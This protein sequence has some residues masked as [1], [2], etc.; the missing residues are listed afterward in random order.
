M[1]SLA[2]STKVIESQEE[3]PPNMFGFLLKKLG[4]DTT[5]GQIMPGIDGLRALAVAWVMVFHIY[6]FGANS[7]N[8]TILG[9]F[10]IDPWLS[11]GYLSVTLFFALSGFLL[12][13]PWAKN[14]HANLNSPALAK[15]FRRRFYRIA[16]AYYVQI[17]ILFLILAP[18]ALPS[19]HPFSPLGIFTIFSHL[20]LTHYLFPMTSAGLGINGALWTLTIEACFYIV[21]PFVARFFLG[22]CALLYLIVSLLIAEIWRFFSFHALYDFLVWVTI[23]LFPQIA[24]YSYNPIVM[25]SFLANQLPGH[26]FNFAIGMYLAGLYFD[27]TK[28]QKKIFE[29]RSGGMLTTTFVFIL[30]LLAWFLTKPEILEVWRLYV[31]FIPVAFVCALLVF[32]SSFPNYFSI[33]ILGAPPVRVLGIISYSVYLWHFPIVYF[34]TTHWVPTGIVGAAKFYF[35]LVT[36]IPPTILIGYFSYRYIELPFLNLAKESYAPA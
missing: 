29:N 19:W 4:H 30:A 14:N 20:T 10:D 31:L 7:P 36:C 11:S 24:S 33:R 35:L 5:S 26:A 9:L 18:I 27:L 8:I 3:K 23:T 32:L 13:I 6:G 16:P 22:R 25:K 17:L 12:M 21:L 28:Q 2:Q 1:A 15:Y 34:A